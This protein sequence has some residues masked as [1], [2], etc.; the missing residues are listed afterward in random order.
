MSTARTTFALGLAAAALAS[1]ASAQ[2]RVSA[3]NVTGYSGGRTTEFQTAIYGVYDGRSM[4]PDFILGSEFMSQ[5]G[6]NAFVAL[7]NTAPGSP[8][9][10]AAAPFIDGPD[11]DSAFFYRTGK[12]QFIAAVLVAPADPG[13][14]GQPR[15]TMRY[16][17]RPA[18]YSAA[19]TTIACYDVHLKSGTG[20]GDPD[21]R[22]VETQRIRADAQ[23]LPAGWHFLVGGDFNIRNSTEAAY[24]ALVG[25]AVT[26]RFVDPI[27]TPGAWYNDSAF[28]FVHTQAPGGAASTSGGMDDRH[29]QILLSAGLLDGHGFDYIG[30]PAVAY[31]N[32]TW[33]D[34]NHSYRAWGNDGTSF[35]QSLTIAGNTMVGPVIAQAL[36][37]S[38]TGG[39]HLPV[40]LDL[41]VP[42]VAGAD[43]VIDFGQVTVG[44]TAERTL[45]VANTAD[46]ARWTAGGIATLSY[47]L[48]ASA[49][50]TAPAGPFTDAAGTA[51]EQHT[52]SMD[53]STP[54][55]FSGTVAITTNSPETP[56]LTVM[57]A[58][59]VVG[60]PSCPADLNGDGFVDFADYLVFL[61]LYDAGC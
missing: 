57:L 42:P 60:E 50:F 25:G 10:W 2:L 20:S 3:W 40:F 22:L 39:G 26:G 47:S 45:T 17:I 28:R 13:T 61:D 24:Q 12:V 59:E 58:G 23:A 52:I 44:G 49:G 32:S 11:T 55:V 48:S 18:G 53:T 9:D 5:S 37:D 43:A 1:T 4:A 16:D 27:R 15:N 21:R 41:R 35:N 31:S 6:V 19:A 56:V 8:G 34:P 54:G 30:N 46:L 36:Y 51:P 14:T 38:A 33:N 29:D 7:L